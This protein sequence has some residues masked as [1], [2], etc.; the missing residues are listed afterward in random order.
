MPA[1]KKTPK[2][3]TRKTAAS[4]S[5]PSGRAPRKTAA[6]KAAPRKGASKKAAQRRKPSRQ[7]MEA[8]TKGLSFLNKLAFVLLI[9]LICVAVGVTVFPQ[10]KQLKR[11]EADLA[12]TQERETH[13]I[14]LVDQRSRELQ[15]LRSDIAF[16]ELRSRDVLNWYQPSA[17]ETIIRIQRD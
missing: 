5:A 3:A 10:L 11:L 15:A 9:I 7:V 12:L 6:R 13:A 1:A 2:K 14:N 16:Q 17:G 8:R 4:R